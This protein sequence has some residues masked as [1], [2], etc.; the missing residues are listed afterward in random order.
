MIIQK[1]KKK[2]LQKIDKNCLNKEKK[3]IKLRNFRKVSIICH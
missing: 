2:V 3:K 1:K